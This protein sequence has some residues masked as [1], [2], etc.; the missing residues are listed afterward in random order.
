M[1]LI[2]VGEVLDK[3]WHYYRKHFSELMNISGWLLLS[4]ALSVIGFALLPSASA[5]FSGRDFTA[6]EQTGRVILALNTFIL[7]P[8][9]SIWVINTL[10]KLFQAQFHN[11]TVT[12]KQVAIAGRKLFW[13]AVWVTILF[14]LVMLASLLFLVPGFVFIALG[15]TISSGT[16]LPVLG[17]LLL[18]AGGGGAT[19]SGFAAF[20]LVFFFFFPPAL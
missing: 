1:Q 3:S 12:L 18:V 13:P 2:S 20:A 7:T 6:V 10:I 11:Q 4:A 5:L 16:A 14:A 17:S 9:L 19:I 15:S 8:A